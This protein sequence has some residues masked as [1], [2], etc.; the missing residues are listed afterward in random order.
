MRSEINYTTRPPPPLASTH[1]EERERSR[2]EREEREHGDE[3]DCA[4][5][6][7]VLDS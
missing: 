4:R 5:R 3:R 2:G 7:R 1:G 6:E